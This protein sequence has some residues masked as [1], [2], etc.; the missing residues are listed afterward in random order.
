[1]KCPR[2][3]EMF[4]GAGARV[5]KLPDEDHWR[6]NNTCSYCGSMNPDEFMAKCEAGIVLGASDK[7]Y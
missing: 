3:D 5:F 1:M 7:S 4:G 6:E 2:R